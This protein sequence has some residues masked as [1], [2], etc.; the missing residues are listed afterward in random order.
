MRARKRQGFG[1]TRWSRA[2]IYATLGLFNGYRGVVGRHTRKR[3]QPIGHITLEAKQAGKRSAGNP[4]ATFEEAGAGNG[5]TVR[6]VRHSQRKR[7][8]TDRPDLRVT[9][10]VLD[11]TLE[12]YWQAILDS[13]S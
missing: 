3:S 1:W 5:I 12:A 8:A 10:P 13:D 9:A 4:H 6:L 2:W 7:G 11:P